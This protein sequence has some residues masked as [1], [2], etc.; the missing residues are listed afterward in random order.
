MKK[1]L[2][3]SI[4][5][6]K[7]LYRSRNMLWTMSVRDLKARYVGSMFGLMWAVIFP[8]AQFAIYGI[9]FG[10]FFKSR[11]DPVYGTDS[12]FLYLLTGLLPWIFFSQAMNTATSTVIMNQTLIKKAVGFPSEILPIVKVISALMSHMIG[13]VIIFVVL[14]IFTGGIPAYAPFILIYLFFIFLFAV[15]LGWIFSSLNVYLRDI[16]QVIGLILLGWFFFTPIFYSSSRIPSAFLRILELNPMF[17]MVD[18]YRYILLAGS[19]PELW[20]LV[21]LI[22]VSFVTLAIGGIFF[23]RLKPGFADVL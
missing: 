2:L 3:I 7:R 23:R 13:L 15:G 9:I 4:D 16:Q 20:K 12:F 18:G 19:L 11:P 5:F 1:N 14:I 21:Y 10:V 17:V 22:C 8:L 6:A